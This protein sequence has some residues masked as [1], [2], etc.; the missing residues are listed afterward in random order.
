M[1]MNKEY[2]EILKKEFYYPDDKT[3]SININSSIEPLSGI[4]QLIYANSFLNNIIKNKNNEFS[5][6]DIEI[7]R[8]IQNRINRLVSKVLDKSIYSFKEVRI[9]L[10]YS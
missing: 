6:E 10:I 5:D 4:E 7:A 2:F 1:F 8:E 3:I 9:M